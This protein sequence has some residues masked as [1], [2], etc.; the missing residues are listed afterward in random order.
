MV[1]LIYNYCPQTIKQRQQ[2]LFQNKN[3]INKHSN[4]KPIFKL[5]TN[6]YNNI[7]QNNVENII[8]NENESKNDIENQNNNDEN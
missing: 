6:D 8:Q 2:I 7:I 3:N 1:E 5:L 4:F